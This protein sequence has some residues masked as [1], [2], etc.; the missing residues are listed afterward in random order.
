MTGPPATRTGPPLH[1][2]PGGVQGVW[3]DHGHPRIACPASRLCR[4]LCD[5]GTWDGHRPPPWRWR[6]LTHTVLLVARTPQRTAAPDPIQVQI[7][8]PVTNTVKRTLGRFKDFAYGG[9][10]RDD[11][12]LLVAG[13]AHPVVQLFDVKSRGILRSFRG[14]EK[15]AATS[16]GAV[17]RPAVS[18]TAGRRA[19]RRS[20]W[21]RGCGSAVRVT[22]FSPDHSQIMSG[23]DDHTVRL[24]DVPGQTEILCLR[25]HEV[26]PAC[27]PATHGL[28]WRGSHC[29]CARACPSRHGR[30]RCPARQDYIRAG[31][32]APDNANLL[33]SGTLPAHTRRPW[34]TQPRPL[35]KLVRPLP[36]GPPAPLPH[37]ASL[38]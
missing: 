1:T 15:C 10:F 28:R 34:P 17:G 35:T 21:R 14:H 31:T 13:G 33:V 6:R 37:S 5:A 20:R 23:S 25:G 18:L 26:R 11:G 30:V 8:S 24:W 32:V 16:Q 36:G 2:V 4:Q 22:R 19:G 7:Y 9:S 3:A 12:K 27:G 38:V 29:V